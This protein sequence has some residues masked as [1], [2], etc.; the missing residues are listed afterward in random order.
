MC[1]KIGRR[2]LVKTNTSPRTRSAR[3]GSVRLAH[4]GV[5]CERLHCTTRV[6]FPNPIRSVRPDRKLTILRGSAAKVPVFIPCTGVPGGWFCKRAGFHLLTT[7]VL[8]YKTFCC[9]RRRHLSWNSWLSTQGC[10]VCKARNINMSK[11]ECKFN[12]TLKSRISVSEIR[13]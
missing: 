13:Q 7:Y 9:A 10:V 1:N 3:S 5:C 12:K 4:L 11:L 8:I 2:L 6:C